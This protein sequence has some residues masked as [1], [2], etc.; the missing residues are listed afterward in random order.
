MH[1]GFFFGF[2]VGA[3]RCGNHLNV[4]YDSDEPEMCGVGGWE[5]CPEV[6]SANHKV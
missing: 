2:F 5:R 1:S 6:V 3:A 4:S